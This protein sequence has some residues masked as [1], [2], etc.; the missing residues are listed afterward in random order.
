MSRYKCFAC[1]ALAIIAGIS[2]CGRAGRGGVEVSGEVHFDGKPLANG[3]VMFI[4]EVGTL[5]H[6]ASA[7]V[8]DGRFFVEAGLGP[9]PGK[10]KAIVMQGTAFEELL[11]DPKRFSELPEDQ[12]ALALPTTELKIVDSPIIQIEASQNRSIVIHCSAQQSDDDS[13]ESL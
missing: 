4:P 9:L 5:G 1:C 12:L 3:S 6:K 2:G 8:Q 7:K 11:D 10:Y 13:E